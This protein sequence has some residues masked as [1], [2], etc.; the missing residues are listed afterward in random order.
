MTKKE[1]VIE[2]KNNGFSNTE[3]EELAGV[4]KSYVYQ[5]CG[6]KGH[7][8]YIPLT[9]EQCVYPYWRNWLNDRKLSRAD[10]VRMLLDAGFVV[11]HMTL[12]AWLTGTQYPNKKHIDVILNITGLFYEDLFYREDDFD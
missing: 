3:I 1:L 11:T 4:S 7:K 8:K 9:E 10:F 2:L 12:S 5:L 6:A